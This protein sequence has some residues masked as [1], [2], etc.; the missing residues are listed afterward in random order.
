MDAAQNHYGTTGQY[1]PMIFVGM[2]Q[3]AVTT[4]VYWLI[5]MLATP[6]YKD[7][8][9]IG[10]EPREIVKFIKDHPPV[11]KPPKKDEVC[12]FIPKD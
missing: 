1:T 6:S 7:L 12:G 2:R 8:L 4:P 9:F 5:Q 10:D 3:Y 11:P